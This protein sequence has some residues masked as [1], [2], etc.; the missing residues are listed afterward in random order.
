[1]SHELAAEIRICEREAKAIGHS[2]ADFIEWGSWKAAGDAA[3]QLLAKLKELSDLQEAQA[4]GDRQ[5]EL[6]VPLYA[7][8]A[9]MALFQGGAR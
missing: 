2:V 6:A 7:G 3:K 4:E 5:L 9:Q 1:M 8:A